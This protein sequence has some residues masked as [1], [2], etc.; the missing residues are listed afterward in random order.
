VLQ[1]AK[2]LFRQSD[3]FAKSFHAGIAMNQA[4]LRICQC[5]TD[6]KRPRGSSTIEGFE[7]SVLITQSGVYQG[8]VEGIYRRSSVREL[9]RLI[10][11]AGPS[12]GVTKFPANLMTCRY[13]PIH[14][15][16]E[17]LDCFVDPPLA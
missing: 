1:I 7:R 13:T 15:R 11:P 17:D 4:E 6:P 16:F 5:S 3:F 9:L 12:I 14:G 8:F 2:L 10:T